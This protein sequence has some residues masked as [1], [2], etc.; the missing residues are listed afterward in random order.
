MSHYYCPC[1][2]SLSRTSTVQSF[3]SSGLR[4]FVS[5]RTM[6]SLSPET[7]VCNTCRTAYYT[8]ENINI[9]FGDILSHIDKQGLVDA[10]GDEDTNSVKKNHA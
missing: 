3:K 8:W 9:E 4:L 6:K 5:I 1:G 2:M 10:S 7:K